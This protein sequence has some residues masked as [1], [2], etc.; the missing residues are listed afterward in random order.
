[1]RRPVRWFASVCCGLA[2]LAGLSV[3]SLTGSPSRLPN[4]AAAQEKQ[5]RKKDQNANVPLLVVSVAGVERLLEDV[6]YIFASAGRPELSETVGGLLANLRDL[7]GLERGQSMGMMLFLNGIVP[8]PVVFVPV[9]NIDDMLR[10]IT[11][12]PITTEKTG[13]NRYQIKANNQ[14]LYVLTQGNYAFVS[15]NAD[16]LDRD[17]ADPGQVTRRLAATYDIAAS[18]N[19]RA[20]PKVTRDLF[21]DFMRASA[22]SNLQQHDN[23]PD[24]AY[25]L[26]KASGMSNLAAIEQ[27]ITQG[28]ELTLGWTISGPDKLAALELVV[29]ADPKSEYAAYLNELRGAQSYFANLLQDTVPLTVSSALLLDKPLKK[30]LGEVLKAAEAQMPAELSAPAAADGAAAANPVGDLFKSLNATLETGRADFV[31]QFV[32]DP[33]GPFVLVGGAKVS[34]GKLLSNALSDILGKLKSSPNLESVQLNTAEHKGV[35]LHRLQ[36][37]TVRPPEERLY[38]KNMGIY[39]G[40]GPEAFWFAVGGDEALP[41]LR[42]AIDLASKRPGNDAR[43]VPFQ[44]V[45]HLASWLGL[46]DDPNGRNPFPELA[47]DAFSQASDRIVIDLRPFEDG[48]RLRLQF[49][50]GFIRLLGLALARRI[51]G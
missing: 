2:V 11:F 13:D 9:Q 24:S 50:E 29:T 12:G 38:G 39:L 43:V 35:T 6:D 42:E 22:E 45:V 40:A 4:E 3:P 31:V 25:R 19:L 14:T 26:R 18:V 48:A 23:E 46:F 33:P 32:G 20:L 15:N 49:D 44:V 51:D 30:F 36:P 47:R 34:D 21:L 1:M 16:M 37:K 41:Q 10:T 17:F 7:K 8:Q 5:A 28:E 27:V